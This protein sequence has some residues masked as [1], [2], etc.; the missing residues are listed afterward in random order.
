MRTRICEEE[1][2]SYVRVSL[3]QDE[4]RIYIAQLSLHFFK[5]FKWFE[6]FQALLNQGT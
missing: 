1:L 3:K 2:F 5:P 4:Y 6:S